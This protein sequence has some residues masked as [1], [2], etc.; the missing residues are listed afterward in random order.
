MKGEHTMAGR[1]DGKVALVTGGGSGIGR[2]SALAFAREGAQVVVAD[3]TGDGGQDTV[4]LITAAGGE[5]LFIT[6]DVARAAAVEALIK[7]IMTTYGRLDCAHNNAGVEGECVATS[8]YPEADWDR[9]LAI[10]LLVF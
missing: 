2:A 8:E 9:V 10:N 3:V 7:Q 4:R 1:L 6:T 5:G